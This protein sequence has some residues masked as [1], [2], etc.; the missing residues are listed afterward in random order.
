MR[1][2]DVMIGQIST[3][4][5][6]QQGRLM[7]WAPV[8][9]AFGIG[10][11]FSA[12]TEPGVWLL[13]GMGLVGACLSLV[14]LRLDP[15]RGPLVWALALMAAGFALA[16]ARTH[17]VAGPVLEFRYYGP[18]EGRVVGLDRSASGAI[19]VTLADVRL[20]RMDPERV[21]RHVR[22]SLHS[23]TDQPPM[24]GARIMTTGHLSP[25]GGPTEPGG[26]DFQRHTWFL[27]LG[28]VGYTRVPLLL[29]DP[30]RAGAGVFGIRMALSDY[31]QEAIPGDAGG[32]AA[33]ITTGDR[34]GLTPEVTQNL[35]DTNLAHL[36]AISGLH[37]GLLTG[38]I[39]GSLRLVLALTP[40]SNIWPARKFA[41][42]GALAVGVVYLALS[43]GNVATERAF[44]MVA[45]ALAA[46]IL[47]RRAISLRSV[48]VAAL[49]VLALRP[50]ALLSPGFQMSFSATIALV[51][52]FGALTGSPLSRGPGWSRPVLA[53]FVSASVAGFA[54]LPFAAA[55]F[56][57]MAS[58]GLIANLVA[59]PV[60]GTVVVPA[61]VLA[62]LLAPLG[63]D[64]IGFW[65]MQQGLGWILAV[66]STVAAWE[67]AVRHIPAPPGQ[68]LPLLAIGALAVVLISGLGRWAGLLPFVAGLLIWV[69][70]ER[71]T[72]LI[73]DTGTL[74]GVLTEEGRALTKERGAGFVARNWL[75]NDGDG[76]AQAE[77]AARWQDAAKVKAVE[78][79]GTWILH[80]SGKRALASLESCPEGYILVASTD[81]SD[82]WPCR[83]L[84]PRALRES[85]AIAL[86]ARAGA[87]HEKTA[88]Q[89]AGT[90]L[91][92]D[93]QT[94]RARLAY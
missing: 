49:I 13:W 73:A 10:A 65:I 77:A 20:S 46:V 30:E 27:S 87:L 78:V 5:L 94:R 82:P 63:L 57:R 54:T 12:G 39:F 83:V 88:R 1:A 11:F 42:L 64:G 4:L 75:E 48:A 35:R 58:F 18:I 69:N 36:L 86:H 16:G 33:A 71:P 85:G 59:P 38:F 21:P 41:A 50:E 47:D 68:V 44:V 52:A 29:A 76:V 2:A 26:F 17:Y 60:M 53:L 74:V 40:L 15:V 91:W 66:A 43:G 7:P 79:A 72:V 23:E 92:N 28:A 93:T 22:V 32:F 19:R 45:V 62:T 3:A 81:V 34:S 37:M 70:S 31:V 67:G 61:G 6:S 55:H 25:P 14:A 9:F 80:A 8:F 84:D 24:P 51:A 56:N 90:R 89:V